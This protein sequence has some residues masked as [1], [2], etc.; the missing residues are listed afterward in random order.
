MAL[1][2]TGLTPEEVMSV[3]D[4]T[5]AESYRAHDI[6]QEILI[7]QLKSRGFYVEQHGDDA[8]HA[9]EV[10]YGSGPDLA[11]YRLAEDVQP[12]TDGLGSTFI[13]TATGQFVARERALELVA[14]VECKCKEQAE[15]FGRC[16]LRH[17]RE[18]VS[19]ANEESVP[20]FIWFA[21]VDGDEERVL[22]SAFVAVEDTD[23]IKGDV[24]DVS[25]QQVVFRAEDFAHVS[26]D[27][28]LRYVEAGDVVGVRS[29]D[30]IVDF[31][32]SIHGN[33]VIEL[34]DDDF[35]SWPHFVH[36]IGL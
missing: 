3:R 19:F 20:V 26:E 18:Y 10:F 30:T 36:V 6:G 9:D 8:R 13:D 22:R 5:L 32:P 27:S 15:W 4:R 24:V 12:N 11:V 25:D 14:Y 34:N 17:F 31:L 21:L 7:A 28:D 33:D 1:E 29:R 2:E 35:R 16:N 23:Q